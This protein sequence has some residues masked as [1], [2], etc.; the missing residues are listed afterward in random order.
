[1]FWR[2][3]K[4]HL[5]C[6]LFMI[7]AILFSTMLFGQTRSRIAG[8]VKDVSTGDPLPGANVS[9]SGTALGA[10][11][12]V[13]G[14]FIIVNAP[15]GTYELRVTMMGY[16]TKVL[17]N[18]MV[19]LDRIT[20]LNI[21]LSTT[22]LSGNE[23]VVVAERDELHKEVSNTQMV[24]SDAQ[25]TEATGIRQINAFLTK[26]PG[27][28]EDN[29]YL[30]IR[31]G[32]AD[33]TGMMVNGL[34]Y[35]NLGNGSAETSIPLSAIEQVSLLSGGYDAEYGNFRSGLI[36]I[37]TKSGTKDGY[38]GTF[39]YS[40]DNSHMRRFGDSFYSTNNPYLMS[41]LDPSIAFIGTNAA[42]E[43]RD[44]IDYLKEQHPT[45]M[46]WNRAAEIYNFGKEP[47]DQATPLDYYLLACWMFM[48]EPDYAGL[49][50]QGY[51]V[52]EAQQKLFADH[53]MKEDG[54][55]WNF[56][57]GFGGPLPF[58]GKALGDATF[59]ISNN[60][61]EQHYVMPVVL[62]SEKTYTTLAT[63]KANPMENLT[64]TF[65]GLWKDQKG[66]SPIRPAW[67]DFPDASREGGFMPS[68]NIK[69]IA[70]NPEYWYDPPFYPILYQN[71][72]MGGLT[73]NYIFN[74][75]TF[76]EFSL[77]GLRI[78]NSSPVCNNRDQTVVT[79]FGPF[80]VSEMPYGKLQYG[81]NRLAYVFG[82]TTK[83]Y[84]YPSY[85]ALPDV[86]QRFRR[87]EG[88]LYDKSKVTQYRARLDL[89]SQMNL[90]HYLKTGIEY[91]YI[92]LD[93]NLWEKWN[94]NYYNVYE[95]NYFRTPSQTGFYIQD[96]I[97]YPA[98][99]ANLGLR[100][101]Y[102]YGGGGD[103]PTGDAFATDV[104]IP[105]KF[106]EDSIL[107][108][109]LEQ[110]RSY[111]WDLWKQY[112]KEHPGFLQPIKNHFTVSPRIGISFP[113]TVNSKF[114]FNY[115]HFRSNPPYYTMY[116]YRYRYDKNGLY[117]MSN[118]NLEPPRTIS[119]ELGMAID[120]FEGYVLRISGYSKDVTGEQGQINY[121]N[122]S[123]VD[124]EAWANN[125]Y[126]D[127]Q[128]L[129]INLTKND[130][131]WL[132]GWINFNYMLKKEGLTGRKEI[133]EIQVDDKAGLYNDQETQ[134][135]P[136]PQ[137]NA[138]ITFRSPSHWGSDIFK[139][140]IFGNWNLTFFAEWK[141][142]DYFTW[143]PEDLEYVK[144][145]RRWPDY[146]MVDM[147]L[148]KTFKWG[149][150]GTTFYVDV[151]NLFNF[152]VNLIDKGYAFTRDSGVSWDDYDWND[153]K[154]YVNSLKSG[155]KLGDLRSAD[156]PYINDPQYPFWLFGQ[157][158]D[159]WVGMQF[160]F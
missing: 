101:D 151:S 61:K 124:Y 129:E 107:F 142:G 96:Q 94:E 120:L 7:G 122:T 46:G 121:K 89:A 103:W 66:V 75:K 87:K 136:V 134:S 150:F 100:F 71:T 147:K 2:K 85:D 132:N 78:Q 15:V 111:I 55:D 48:T 157:P 73:F 19:S 93:N 35:T 115:G 13:D 11:C 30:T 6:M 29:G 69:Y 97:S 145:N 144:N 139:S 24:V 20:R 102:Y 80:P 3:S 1:M 65:N 45:F 28:S 119:Y 109:Y 90:H 156:K 70:K 127:I 52:S 113:V 53:A 5:I 57:G 26:L 108:N 118:P 159:V 137:L 12:D 126:V 51:T 131:S 59:Y 40:R 81:S 153:F 114:Y 27:V 141:A 152:K 83:S 16:E 86:P 123:G 116:L 88:D 140:D 56:D 14:N 60:S 110:G 82:D 17:K 138:N 33:Q 72:K 43:G 91:N 32:S 146:Y 25:L 74:Q 143:N 38:H 36:N 158:R 49:K 155:D 130:N 148:T 112:D 99:I 95:F 44:D 41:Y 117:D 149:G 105:Q 64:V 106:A 37:T 133:N 21:E 22:I 98:I 8:T 160:S 154:N 77:S 79:R 54:S 47:E 135:L 68:D 39:S 76:M 67:G 128:G 18:V 84:N 10:A 58:I 9:V 50:E 63:I 4:S 23:V 31:G 42:W 92:E 62:P 104:F 34:S 125:E